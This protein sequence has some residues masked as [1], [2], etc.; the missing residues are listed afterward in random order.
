MILPH[1]FDV[2]RRR[3]VGKSVTGAL[4]AEQDGLISQ[5]DLIFAHLYVGG[6]TVS[7]AIVTALRAP[8]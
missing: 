1:F 7:S 8:S 5:A 6:C 3:L 4:R 2:I